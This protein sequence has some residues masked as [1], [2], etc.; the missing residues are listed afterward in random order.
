MSA[1]AA[2]D[3]VWTHDNLLGKFPCSHTL[4]R[5]AKLPAFA[6]GALL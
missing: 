2:D 6:V 4:S 5:I 3:G 1:Y